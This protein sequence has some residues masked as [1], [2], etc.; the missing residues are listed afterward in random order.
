MTYF[1]RIFLILMLPKIMP[2]PLILMIRFEC[3]L[4]ILNKSINVHDGGSI[5]M[6]SAFIVIK[7]TMVTFLQDV[8]FTIIFISD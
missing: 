8:R 5:N 4:N 3:I 7:E 2:K 6:I 1:N